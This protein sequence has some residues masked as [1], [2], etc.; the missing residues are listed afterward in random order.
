[1]SITVAQNRLNSIFKIHSLK[2]VE[3][4]I[5]FRAYPFKSKG[6][7]N[8]YKIELSIYY[9]HSRMHIYHVYLKNEYRKLHGS[10]SI[11]EKSHAC[12]AK[13]L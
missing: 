4:Y 13:C 5:F 11:N 6:S 10:R 7:S 3:K 12:L 2:A 8:C 9:Y 1:M